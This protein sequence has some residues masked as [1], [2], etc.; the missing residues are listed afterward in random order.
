[1]TKVKKNCDWKYEP[2]WKYKVRLQG[3]LLHYHYGFIIKIN[4][5]SL[6]F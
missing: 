6:Y 2:F 3:L 4:S 5:I 1:M